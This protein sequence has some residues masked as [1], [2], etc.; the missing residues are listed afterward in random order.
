MSHLLH[1][2]IAQQLARHVRERSVVVWYDPRSEFESFMAELEVVPGS[3][4]AEAEI[5]GVQVQVASYDES[6][7]ALRTAVEPLVQGDE[8]AQLVLYLRGL[9]RSND[10]PLMELELAGIRWKPQLRKLARNALE[11]RFTAGV[12]DELLDRDNLEYNDIVQAAAAAGGT[13]GDGLPSV[14]KT[15][16]GGGTP[17]A[18][19]S[20]WLADPELDAPIVEKRAELELSKLIGTRLGLELPGN[21]I[22]KWRAVAARFV[23]AVEFR[24]DLRAEPPQELDSIPDTTVDV[25]RRSR[26]IAAWLRRNAADTYPALA[27][28]VERELRL[29]ASSVDPLA[30]GAIDTFRFEE[31]ALLDRCAGLVRQGDYE[32]AQ[33]VSEERRDSFWLA[34]S[35]DRQAQWEAIDLAAALGTKAGEIEAA[36]ANAPTSPAG[37]IEQYANEWHRLDRAQ[38]RLEAWLPKLEE[39]PDERVMAAVRSSYEAVLDKLARGFAAS[40]SDAGWAVEGVRKQTSI[41]DSLVRPDKGRVAFFLVDAM[42]YEMGVELAERLEDHGEVIIDPAVGVLPSITV[43][44]MAA[45]MPGAST[46]YDV[47]EHG[48]KLAVEVDGSVLPDLRAR[49]RHLAARAPSSLDLDLGELL[50]LS[51]SRLTTRIGKHDL[52]VVRSQE[53]DAFGEGGFS[54]RARP[55]MDTTINDLARAVRRLARAGIG[56]AVIASDHGH[57]FAAEDRDDSMKIEAPGGDKVEL[58]RRCWIGHG[59][60]T[61]SACV[62]V[63]ARELGNDTDL[64]FVFPKSCGVFKAGGDLSFHHG[65]PTLQEMVIRSSPFAR[66]RQQSKTEEQQSSPLGTCLPPSPTG[67]SA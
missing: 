9:V 48:G 11:K 65:G 23:L 36:L 31:Q 34:D 38:R 22:S 62:R 1:D 26:S 64:E 10:S 8:P 42:R 4:L 58:H 60:S 37:W 41:F 40:L 6:I 5:D 39:E 14:L 17:E 7:Y 49:K 28:K 51:Q 20:A 18:Q 53:I 43:T 66:L 13:G 67:C 35:V 3:G 61:T 24:S 57:L 54:Y 59:G 12:V 56:R 19:L 2:Y 30:L 32:Q 21:D 63:D 25:E 44:G 16:I 55:V 47:I 15:I 52:I 50:D 27:D 33:E 45:L 46:N 29:K